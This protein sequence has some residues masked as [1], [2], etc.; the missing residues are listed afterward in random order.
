MWNPMSCC[1]PGSSVK[2]QYGGIGGVSA[3]DM[4]FKTKQKCGREKGLLGFYWG[5]IGIMEKKME[6]TMMGNI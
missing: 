2:D 4:R 5:Y 3:S 1:R 6:T